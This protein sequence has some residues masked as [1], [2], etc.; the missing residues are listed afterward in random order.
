M[1]LTEFLITVCDERSNELLC[2]EELRS[3]ASGELT[4]DH[5]VLAGG[6]GEEY[7]YGFLVQPGLLHDPRDHV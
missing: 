5:E 6:K 2:L 4:V 7:Y 3:P 1:H